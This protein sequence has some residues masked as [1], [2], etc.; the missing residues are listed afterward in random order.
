MIQ[1]PARH[2]TPEATAKLTEYQNV[3]DT[4]AD[5]SHRVSLAKKHFRLQNRK[6][7]ATFLEVRATLSQMCAGANRCMYCED[8]A[9]D[10]V[11][12]YFPKDLYPEHVFVWGNYLYACG[13]CNGKKRSKFAVFDPHDNPIDVSRKRN[14]PIAPPTLGHP[15]LLAPRNEN[16]LA[17]MILDIAGDTFLFVPTPTNDARQR[18]RARYTINLLGLNSRDYLPKA[19]RE[20]YAHYLAIFKE[21]VTELDNGAPGVTLTRLTNTLQTMHHPTVWQEMQR[22]RASI[23]DLAELFQR[24]PEALGW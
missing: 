8:S 19:R 23:P 7:N 14:A 3:I 21:Y 18:R 20:A 4:E 24:A 13:P 6:T 12:H 17:F 15:V 1:L 10:E 16:A 22:Q 11:E 9:A 5:Y 2:L